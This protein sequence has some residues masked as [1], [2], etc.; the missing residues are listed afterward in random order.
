MFHIRA[1]RAGVVIT[2][3]VLIVASPGT[4]ADTSSFEHDFSD[5]AK[6]VK[7]FDGPDRDAWQKPSELS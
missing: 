6:Y 1:G 5:I 7:A 3:A 4:A 2:A